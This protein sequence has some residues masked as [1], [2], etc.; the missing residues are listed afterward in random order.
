MCHILGD[1]FTISSGHRA[2]RS[3]IWNQAYGHG[4][5]VYFMYMSIR[6]SRKRKSRKSQTNFYA[7]ISI[8]VFGLFIGKK[9]AS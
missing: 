1:F 2:N 5:G 6:K 4:P 8:N 7:K 3:K 9:T